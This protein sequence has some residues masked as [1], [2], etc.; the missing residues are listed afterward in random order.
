MRRAA[1]GLI[2][3]LVLAGALLARA[4]APAAGEP[5]P[6]PAGSD[7]AVDR[8]L[9]DDITADVE[10]A[11]EVLVYFRALNRLGT[12]LRGLRA[13]DLAVF[14]NDAQIAEDK[15]TLETLRAPGRRI[16]ALVAIDASGSMKGQAFNSAKQ[17]ALTLL[18]QMDPSDPVAVLTFG[19]DVDVLADFGV[20]RG[21]AAAA[22]RDRELDLA[23]GQHTR[24]YDGLR[25]GLEMIRNN[26]GVPRR[27]FVIVLSDG[28]D[29]GSQSKLDDVVQLATGV[30]EQAP[31]LVFA[32]GYVGRAPESA[33]QAL[34]QLAERAGGSFMRADSASRVEDFFDAATSQVLSSY[35]VRF[36]ADFD[37]AKHDIRLA[38]GESSAMRPFK[39]PPG[40]G[41]VWPMLAAL[42]VAALVVA[43]GALVFSWWRSASLGRLEVMSGQSKGTTFPLRPGRTR[44]GANE[45]NDLT[46][47]TDTV[48]RYHAEIIARGRRVEI[49]DLRSKNGTF[50]NGGAIDRRHR[51][52]PG[53]RIRI[54]D[55]ELRF[56]R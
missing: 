43:L 25:K 8:L 54:A 12:P 7:T 50:V 40:S 30:E 32:I 20:D 4:Q 19:D 1:S 31:I 17:A 45:D 29:D 27:A 16:A 36:P 33:T 44:I 56:E 28:E 13:A 9:I 3:P 22:V 51:L 18:Q 41:S 24:L 11:H 6:A 55:V 37:D 48:S 10:P 15:L 46:L 47:P 53:D 34:K 14:D 2:A 35:V 52:R 21:T 23:R 42:G 38:L 39:Y 5:A 49:E 26:P